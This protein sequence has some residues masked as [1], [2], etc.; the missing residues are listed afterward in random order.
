MDLGRKINWLDF[1]VKSSK[2]NVDE[3]KW[4]Q[5][6]QRLAYLLTALV[7]FCLVSYSPYAK[8]LSCTLLQPYSTAK[9]QTKWISSTVTLWAEGSKVGKKTMRDIV[10]INTRFLHGQVSSRSEIRTHMISS[11]QECWTEH[12]GGRHG[13][14]GMHDSS[15]LQ[16]LISARRQQAPSTRTVRRLEQPRANTVRW[17][18]SQAA[19]SPTPQD[20]HRAPP[21]ATIAKPGQP[22]PT[23]GRAAF[24]PG[25]RVR[26][27]IMQLQYICWPTD[28]SCISQGHAVTQH[29]RVGST[30]AI[31]QN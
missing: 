28:G 5:N 31:G 9:E 15:L 4:G 16:R 7:Q 14:P 13:H 26:R 27:D 18:T 30:P 24:P 19:A 10:D 12:C 8:R 20:T 1:E 29:R 23:P 17:T 2:V 22:T 6:W 3:T 21:P 11:W 25:D